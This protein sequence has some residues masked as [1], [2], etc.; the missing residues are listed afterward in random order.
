MTVS[1]VADAVNADDAVNLGQVQAVDDRLT[2]INSDQTTS[3]TNNTNAI[4]QG[5]NVGNGTT[6]NKFALGDTVNITADS[7]TKTTTTATGVELGLADNITVESV[8]A[9]T[10]VL[11]TNGLQ[12]GNVVIG[13]ETGFNAGFTTVSGVADAVNADDAVNLGQVSAID[14]R[15][16]AEN[17][18]QTTNITNNTNAI[19]Q[20]F[21]VGN[22]TTSNKF[23]LGDTVNITADRNTVVTT[24]PTGVQVGL[25]ND[26]F[27][28]SVTAGDHVFNNDGLRMGNVFLSS[29]TG[30]NNGGYTVSG[31][32]NAVNS[33][34]AVNLGQMQSAIDGLAFEN[35]SVSGDGNIVTTQNGTDVSLALSPDITVD[36]V[37]AGT[38]ISA[39]GNTLDANGLSVG[40]VMV[41]NNGLNNNGNTVTGV[42]N[43]VNN[44]DAVNLGQMNAV[45][46]RLTAENAAQN[47][48]ISGKADTSYVDAAD[49][50]LQAQINVKADISYVDAADQKL[51]VQIDQKVDRSEFEASQ[52]QQNQALQVE[53][54]RLDAADKNLQV[55][56]D[57]KV[58]RTEFTADQKRQDDMVQAVRDES[59]KADA[60]IT[61]NVQ[62]NTTN[63]T[64][65][66]TELERLEE[67]KA[68][69]ADLEKKSDVSYVDSEISKQNS[70]YS[71][72]SA[73]TE[74]ANQEM[75]TQVKNDQAIVD[76]RQNTQIN[77][78]SQAIDMLGYKV[79]KLEDKLSAG[80]ASTVAM[81]FMPSAMIPGETRISGGTG[82]YNGQSAIAIGLTGASDTGYLN[83]K[84]G[85][86]YTQEGGVVVGGGVSYR[87][88]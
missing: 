37:T 5:F 78:N 70:Y 77:N 85:S 69:K 39:G 45:D 35:V 12:V 32:A 62:N 63:I 22:G 72:L 47:I 53:A 87:L 73:Q 61:A 46:D 27:F 36:S 74:Q 24:T 65:N 28:N 56:V 51:Q 30:L 52:Q 13:T 48:V 16:T 38:S 20:G 23:D 82:Y 83:Y 49:Q 84:I 34:D 25:A 19:N 58:D 68:D 43:A 29:T 64:N 57:N 1:G 41:S 60:E 2:A 8:T 9:G 81:A 66:T 79:G 4:N 14:D 7:N 31:V 42:A 11:G 44:D 54:D 50:N 88:W 18:V 59:E 71:E 76:G 6:S 40:G 15:L 3:I 55:Q 86:S 80:I 33:D 21:N 10:N 67:A 17:V 26:V 75:V